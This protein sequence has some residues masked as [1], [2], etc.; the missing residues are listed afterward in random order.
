MRTRAG[1][2]NREPES[3][4]SAR[5][6]A[7]G[8][9]L[10]P[11]FSRVIPANLK[12]EIVVAHGCVYASNSEHKRDER[13]ERRQE[14]DLEAGWRFHGVMATPAAIE[15]AF[16]PLFHWQRTVVRMRTYRRARGGACTRLTAASSK[17]RESA[18]PID[19]SSLVSFLDTRA[20]SSYRQNGSICH[21]SIYWKNDKAHRKKLY[22]S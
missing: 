15:S 14:K 13:R 20:R 18:A 11:R 5:G 17:G 2:I 3:S 10:S 6:I 9:G 4:S 22:R 8:S 21:G 16:G 1:P 12:Q 7:N 19:L